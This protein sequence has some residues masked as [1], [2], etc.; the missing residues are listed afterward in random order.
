MKHINKSNILQ[1]FRGS[2]EISICSFRL[3]NIKLSGNKN[4]E[5]KKNVIPSSSRICQLRG[6]YHNNLLNFDNT[7]AFNKD[8]SWYDSALFSPGIIGRASVHVRL[9]LRITG[10]NKFYLFLPDQHDIN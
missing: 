2:L 10:E 3:F 6:I 9:N 5:R 7:T 4:I 1:L 8:P